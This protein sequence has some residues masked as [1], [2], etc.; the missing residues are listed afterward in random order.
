MKNQI[1]VSSFEITGKQRKERRGKII[2]M[3]SFLWSIWKT[4]LGTE[5]GYRFCQCTEKVFGRTVVL[6]KQ[7]GE[8]S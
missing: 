3:A 7:C 4:S 8:I 6:E 2:L 1:F 5:V